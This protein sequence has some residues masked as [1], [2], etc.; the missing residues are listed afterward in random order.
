MCENGSLSNCTRS[1][2]STQSRS[3]EE[4]SWVFCVSQRS[5]RSHA[6]IHQQQHWDQ[7][8]WEHTQRRRTEHRDREERK[9]RIERRRRGKNANSF[10]KFFFLLHTKLQFYSSDKWKNE[11]EH[12]I[13]WPYQIKP[14]NF[15]E[16]QL[17][18]WKSDIRNGLDGLGGFPTSCHDAILYLQ[19]NASLQWTL[20]LLSSYIV[21]IGG[22]LLGMI[23]LDK[24]ILI[25]L[26]QEI[27]ISYIFC[28]FE[29]FW[30]IFE[31]CIKIEFLRKMA[32]LRPL[33]FVKCVK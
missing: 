29:S 10:C 17:N 15:K 6:P 3:W 30:N 5:S 25:E 14:M 32:A 22:R 21:Y 12:F 1:T 2:P 19:W 31:S 23:C 18:Q 4:L 24:G 20:K 26:L 13:F 7:K 9:K 16:L 8:G 28:A 33:G 27:Q 11:W